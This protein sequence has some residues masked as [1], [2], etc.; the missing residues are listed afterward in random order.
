MRRTV[1]GF[2]VLI[3]LS[4]GFG[5]AP[6]S[7]QE[8]VTIVADIPF[9]FMVENTMLP[10]GKYEFIQTYDQPWEW[11]ANDAKGM[12]KVLFSTEPAEMMKPPRSFEA[13]FDYVGGKYFLTNIWLDGEED[14]YYVAMSRSEK[15]LMK[16]GVRPK[17]ERVPA[18]KKIM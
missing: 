10:A 1:L 17:E 18:K 11:A 6:A 2:L 3:L 14:G 16:K 8:G 5:P 15:A 4:M 13:T 9:A 7:A 12:I